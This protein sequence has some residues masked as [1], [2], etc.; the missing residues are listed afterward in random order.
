[1]HPLRP[2]LVVK[3][4]RLNARLSGLLLSGL[5]S[6]GSA[7]H[8]QSFLSFQQTAR[9]CFAGDRPSCRTAMGLSHQLR[10]RADQKDALRCYTALLGVEAMLNLS[11]LGDPDQERKERVLQQ[12]TQ[13]CQALQI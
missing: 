10:Q 12:A 8:A 5:V 6:T 9:R 7:V 3:I 11:L 2:P 4:R 1:M 13:E